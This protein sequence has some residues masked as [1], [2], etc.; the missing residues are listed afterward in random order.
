MKFVVVP[1]EVTDLP[2]TVERVEVDFDLE[3]EEL[4]ALEVSVDSGDCCEDSNPWSELGEG[5]RQWRK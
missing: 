1:G 4:L 2:G 5:L 3:G